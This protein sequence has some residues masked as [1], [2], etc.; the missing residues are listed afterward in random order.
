[1]VKV[2]SET[3]N[4]RII[5]DNGIIQKTLKE[6]LFWDKMSNEEK[7]W[8]KYLLNN[9]PIFQLKKYSSN[10]EKLINKEVQTYKFWSSLNLR[11]PEVISHSKNSIS[12]SY[13]N[14]VDINTMFNKYLDEKILKKLIEKY[15]EIRN[16]AI[17]NNNHLI[18]H[19]DPQLSNFIYAKD[20]IIPIDP[21]NILNEKFDLYSL[22]NKLSLF[23]VYSIF[24]LNQSQDIKNEIAYEIIL[25]F[26]KNERERL[27]YENLKVKTF[28]KELPK[29][30]P[31]KFSIPNY[32]NKN[33][34]LVEKM[35]K[36]NLK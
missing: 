36:N 2:I 16:L 9:F 1:M 25:S 12:M 22:D 20:E 28:R 8:T 14:G 5:L 33:I 34:Y 35:L 29:E 4:S 24:N 23:F 32:S 27:K 13:I 10:L 31:F 18:L 19:S 21:A 7:K 11:C 26:E 17:E 30:I 6:H 15:Q 3:N